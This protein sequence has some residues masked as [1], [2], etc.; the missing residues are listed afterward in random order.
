VKKEKKLVNNRI[1]WKRRKKLKVDLE[2]KWRTTKKE[3]KKERKQKQGEK[4][5]PLKVMPS[6]LF[7]LFR[8]S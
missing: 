3:R 8:W 7:I 6:F 5:D 2:V 1:I 4:N